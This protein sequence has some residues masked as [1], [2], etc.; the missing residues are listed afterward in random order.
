MA[1]AEDFANKCINGDKR[2]TPL[3]DWEAERIQEGIKKGIFNINGSVFQTNGGTK[4]YKFFGLHREYFTHFAMLVETLSWDLPNARIE[5]P[6]FQGS[7][8]VS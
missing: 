6:L 3:A 4:E 1:A 2:I 5:F 7:C 8:R